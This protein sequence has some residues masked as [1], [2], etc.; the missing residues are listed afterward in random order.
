MANKK[1]KQNRFAKTVNIKNKR[2]NFEYEILDTFVAGVVLK[3]TE[4]KSIR[5]S[6]VSLTDAFCVVDRGEVYVKQMHITPFS[7]GTDQNHDETRVRKLLLNK[8]EITKINSKLEE[9]GLTLIVRRLFINDRGYA[10]LEL[11]LAKGKK[12]HDKR[13]SIK[14]KDIKRDLQRIK[15]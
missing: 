3:G 14:E 10:K 15:Y 2:A 9:K 7:H 5:E 13:E 8:K 1:D 12:L 6:K 4:I 11:G